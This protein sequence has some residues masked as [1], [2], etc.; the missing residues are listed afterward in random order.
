MSSEEICNKNNL[1]RDVISE[2]WNY[3]TEKVDFTW[4]A[5]HVHA[6]QVITFQSTVLALHQSSLHLDEAIVSI[7]VAKTRTYEVIS[8]E[9]SQRGSVD[10]VLLPV[11]PLNQ[12]PPPEWTHEPLC[13]YTE[14]DWVRDADRLC[15][16]SAELGRFFCHITE[17]ITMAFL[18]RQ[19]CAKEPIDLQDTQLKLATMI[20]SMALMIHLRQTL[21]GLLDI[22]D[23]A[24]QEEFDRHVMR[25]ANQ[26][27]RSAVV[28]LN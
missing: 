19:G 14:Q 18:P 26:M 4:M 5:A 22:L 12:L 25:Q 6:H 15:S 9:L 20:E 7:H 17:Q 27:L 16:Q 3:I 8:E 23:M 2:E 1:I 10:D 28:A 13:V 24:R 11:L 21:D